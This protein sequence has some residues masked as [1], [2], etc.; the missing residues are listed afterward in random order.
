MN[1]VKDDLLSLAAGLIFALGLGLSGMT[2]P[3]VVLAFLDITGEWNPSL[4]FVMGGAIL[5]N[6]ATFRW[7]LKRPGPLWRSKFHL[8]ESP[9]IDKRLV[10]GSAIFGVGWG[11]GGICPGPGIVALTSLN[12]PFFVFMGGMVAGMW[13]FRAWDALRRS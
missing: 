8:P 13:L 1:F 5:F 12:T 4:L 6:V 11:L 3:D 10:I 7:I 2:R 9:K